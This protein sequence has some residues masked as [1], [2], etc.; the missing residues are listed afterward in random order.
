MVGDHMGIPRTVV[1][2]TELFV[3]FLVAFRRSC[4][5]QSF[6]S[7]LKRRATLYIPLYLLYCPSF[8]AFLWV[9]KQAEVR[10]CSRGHAKLYYVWPVI[11]GKALRQDF[12][13]A[14]NQ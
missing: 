2:L 14:I 1:F 8:G 5:D 4:I 3:S 13:G 6:G 10:F 9:G 12:R 11:D 7:P